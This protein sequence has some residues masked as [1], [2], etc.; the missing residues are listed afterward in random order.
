MVYSLPERSSEHRDDVRRAMLAAYRVALL[1]G[2]NE[3]GA[4]PRPLTTISDESVIND[5][6]TALSSSTF[7]GASFVEESISAEAIVMF[8]AA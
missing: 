7:H 6:C 5:G 3:I 1:A 8:T 2:M 4:D